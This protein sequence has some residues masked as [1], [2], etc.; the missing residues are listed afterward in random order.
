MTASLALYL[1]LGL[2][3]AVGLICLTALATAYVILGAA[4]DT[5]RDVIR[6]GK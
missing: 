6:G 3:G 1:A 4:F 5:V 2:L